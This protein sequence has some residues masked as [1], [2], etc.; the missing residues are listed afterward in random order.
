MHSLR[1]N[2]QHAQVEVV[3]TNGPPDALNAFEPSALGDLPLVL[4]HSFVGHSTFR[5]LLTA[6][7]V[8]PQLR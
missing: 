5:G 7:C 4:P 2:D 6:P 8:V 3:E 1:P